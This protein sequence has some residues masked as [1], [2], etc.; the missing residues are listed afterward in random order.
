[1]KTLRLSDEDYEALL[2][3]LRAGMYNAA[4]VEGR[5][6]DNDIAREVHRRERQEAI[7]LRELLKPIDYEE[8]PCKSE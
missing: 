4:I 5:V 6:S 7:R 3:A 1:M 8:A 2:D